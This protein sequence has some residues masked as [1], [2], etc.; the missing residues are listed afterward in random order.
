MAFWQASLKAWGDI[1]PD[2]AAEFDISGKASCRVD[3]FIING[4]SQSPSQ[5]VHTIVGP[6]ISGEQSLLELPLLLLRASIHLLVTT[7]KTS[8]PLFALAGTT[9]AAYTLLNTFNASNWMSS[10]QA[11]A[12]ADPTN[13]YVNYLS[14]SAAQ[15]AGL[16][17]IIGNQVFVGVDNT[18]VLD[19]S[20]T[21]RNSVRIASNAAWTKGLFIADFAH[22]PGTACGSWPAFWML[23]SGTWPGNGEIDLIEG[24]NNQTRNQVTVH[25][26]S[27]CNVSVEATYGET[28]TWGSST[29]CDAGAGGGYNGC[30]V[31]GNSKS[32]GSGFNAAG[33]GIYAMHWTSS[34]IKVWLFSKSGSI[35]SDVTKGTP[36][37]SGWGT[38][39]ASFAGCAFDNYFQ[40]MQIVREASLIK[41]RSLANWLSALQH[42]LLWQLG[43]CSIPK[44]CSLLAPGLDVQQVCRG[45]PARFRPE[46]FLDQQRA[47]VQRLILL[48]IFLV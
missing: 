22:I 31:F 5:S 10:F 24:I 45:Q 30:T 27:G 25:S 20:G 36:N 47:C 26:R 21:G 3:S 14:Q 43:R 33:G 44:L 12:I 15:A 13:G 41:Q 28:G 23:G 32:F 46:L 40:D 34:A 8:L 11:Q 2:L 4:N 6:F 1:S 7:M 19:P 9:S 42:R 35:P 39:V 16:Y 29:P 18:S 38:P 17:K 48:F 37:P